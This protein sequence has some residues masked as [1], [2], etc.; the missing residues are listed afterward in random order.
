VAFDRASESLFPLEFAA[1]TARAPRT[2]WHNIGDASEE[3]W[4]FLVEKGL[5]TASF[6][7]QAG[8]RGEALMR[9]YVAGDTIVAY[10]NGF[11]AIGCGVVEEPESY[12]LIPRGSREIGRDDDE[13]RYRMRIRWRA[14]APR[15]ADG[16][17][18]GEVLER[19]GVHHPIATSVSI[20]PDKGRKL[21]E[22]LVER[23]GPAAR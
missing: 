5:I 23:F 4:R 7:N 16:I 14:T 18:P 11:G 17:R 1:P 19:F 10:A 15:L 8:D 6:G 13:H 12:R 22:A 9:G 20:A 2:F 3:W 21:A